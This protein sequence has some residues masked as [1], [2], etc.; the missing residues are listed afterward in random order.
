[1]SRALVEKLVVK[2]EGTILQDTVGYDKLKILEDLFLSQEERDNMLH[3]GI[4]SEALN[5]IHSNANETS[6]VEAENKRN[7]VYGN[8]Y[9]PARP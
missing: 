4:Q 3:E 8:K 1:M 9:H 6:G 2:Y 5:T 7:E